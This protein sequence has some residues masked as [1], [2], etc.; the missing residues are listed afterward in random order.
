MRV[1]S[2]T[3]ESKYTGN[4][5]SSFPNRANFNF[6]P[7]C[8][9]S[10]SSP[11]ELISYYTSKIALI[12][13]SSSGLLVTCAYFPQTVAPLVVNMPSAATFTSIIVPFVITPSDV[14]M[15]EDGFFFTPTMSKQKVVFSSGWL[16]CACLLRM[17]SQ[18]RGCR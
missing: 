1:G 11:Y 3:V 10:K 14:Y 5:A 16:T 12:H 7:L 6:G 4:R 2:F 9:L 17:F 15:L 8:Y 13:P 18:G